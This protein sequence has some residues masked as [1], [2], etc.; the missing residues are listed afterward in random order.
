MFNSVAARRSMPASVNP[1]SVPSTLI[2]S[3]DFVKQPE[4]LAAATGAP[5]DVL[6]V[7][8]AHTL[9]GRTDRRAAA[10]AVASCSRHVLLL[11]A[12]PHCGSEEEFAGL[13]AL[14]TLAGDDAQTIAIRRTRS[15]VGLDVS[16]RVRAARLAL[17]EDERKMHLLLRDYARSVWRERGARSPAARL[18]MTVLLK[19]AASSAWALQCS[20]TQ[21]LRLL[22]SQEELPDQPPLPFEEGETDSSDSEPPAVLGEP[23]L[24][25]TGRELHLL[26][27]LR[28]AAA[29]AALAESKLARVATLLR[30]TSE[31]ALVFTEYRD[32]LNAAVYALA[33]SGPIAVLHGGLSR[34]ERRDAE[35]AFMT[36]RA[37][38]LL[39]TDVAS[40]GLNLHGRCRLVINLELPWNPIRLEQ[41]IGRVDRIGQGRRVH[42]VHVVGRDTTE[43]YVLDRL[44]ARVR[45]IRRSLGDAYDAR[46]IPDTL[47]AAG[48]LGHE[49][50]PEP[51][52]PSPAQVFRQRPPAE[53]GDR[54]VC[55]LL[56]WAR[57][58]DPAADRI[59]T[60]PRR[61]ERLPLATVPPRVRARLGLEPG[62][63]LGFQVAAVC[64]TGR[65]AAGRVV[66]VHIA[67][68]PQAVR[69]ASPSTL[70]AGVLQL[71][72]AAAAP[73]ATGALEPE[74]DAHRRHAARASARESALLTA[75]TGCDRGPQ[76][77][78]V[79]AG[80]F[81]RR[82]LNEAVRQLAG[83]E[84]RRRL[85]AARLAQ[86]VLE[87]SV[88]PQVRAEPIFA[89]VLR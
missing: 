46:P 87:R 48:A 42:A 3:I 69:G 22:G 49:A 27:E 57:R 55:D 39:A 47:L 38:V 44:A 1:W 64:A 56:D 20:L 19:R 14:G 4:V 70:V 8:E 29:V 18:A 83:R 59:P 37:R 86:F 82:A 54:E 68:A 7:D 12:T 71:A 61:G 74:L 28:D 73:E 11:T 13:C 40:E 26:A 76:A 17:T 32:T 24:D 45:K 25:E 53:C 77:A 80:L 81:D 34:I 60:G 30:R 72:H 35:R 21:R 36:G 85:H 51:D 62:V 79:Q 5:W 58:M 52:V 88:E 66:T 84:H 9:G 41:R 23:G 63:V 50:L 78:P 67:L 75:A 15:D 89:L 65:T 6:V 10:A 31:S 2:A 43:S 33:T 16:R